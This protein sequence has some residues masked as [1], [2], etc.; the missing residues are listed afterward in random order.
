MLI[1]DHDRVPS[2]HLTLPCGA[3]HTVSVEWD[4][5][6]GL[7][8]VCTE[9]ID[10][11]IHAVINHLWQRLRESP[12]PGLVDL[13]PTYHTVSILVDPAK[14][15]NQTKETSLTEG[16]VPQLIQFL[17]SPQDVIPIAPRK[18][19]IPVCYDA[20][21]APDLLSLAERLDCTPEELIAIHAASSYTVFMLGFS[22]GFAYMGKVDAKIAAPR[23]NRPRP[24]VAPGSIG[25]AAQQT[26]I[27]P[28][29]TPGG[30]QL[31]G[32]T[33]LRTWRPEQASPCTL[34]PGDEVHFQP[35]SLK[36]YHLLACA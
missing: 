27:Y 18:V 6:Y 1:T 23:H 10:I 11:H 31:I 26:C 36:E 19:S 5:E 16:L 4:G 17:Q 3:T 25:I 9:G 22:P 33:P 20:T 8:L 29:E 15:T 32:R 28:S 35:I 34:Q 30:W 24:R 14:W 2:L 7:S 21:L 12:I 13:I